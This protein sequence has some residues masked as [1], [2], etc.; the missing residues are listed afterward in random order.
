MAE[1]D[2]LLTD[3]RVATMSAGGTPYG[4]IPEAAVAI[5]G[6]RI[7]WIGPASALPA[8]EAAETRSMA[9][10][11]LTPA[12]ID[13]HTHIVF[14]GDRA[15]EFEE[16]LA[17]ASYAD[18]AGRGG[19]IMSTVRATR[20]ASREALRDAALGRARSLMRDGVA[21]LEIKSGYG[22][23]LDTEIRMLEV[24]REVGAETGMSVRT[25]LLAAHVVAP[26]F[27]DDAGAYID[28]ICEQLL[29]AVAE[30]KLAD[31]VDAY[32][33]TLAFD[34]DQVARVFECAKALSLPV[35]LHADQFSDGDGAALA[36]RF[37]A[38]SADHLEYTS[39]AGIAALGARGTVAVLLPGAFV[40]LNESRRPPVAA[41]RAH[42][43]AM[44]VATDCNPGTSPL[45][46]L[47]EAMALACRVFGLT[48]AEALA[49]TTR[50]A[51]AALGLAG[52]RGTLE[53]GRKADI[54]AWD[55]AHP[56]E[57][58]YWLG[59]RPLAELFIDGQTAEV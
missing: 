46:S 44:A 16:R 10:L 23:D 34:A 3:A 6:G 18:I 32:C 40:T 55:V 49:G 15:G 19:G 53:P 59:A 31:A 2:L 1:W 42:G 12:L 5:A 21:T 25:T 17:G 56:R 45:L 38:L 52:D 7:A 33:E 14:G 57:L 28:L 43:V 35:K 54:A 8:T 36:A 24:A 13:C 27:K 29:P 22:L 20:A 41:M 48:P 4:E 47:R 26:E 58:A 39:P 9:G 50:V 11:W 51:A 30:Q 37:G